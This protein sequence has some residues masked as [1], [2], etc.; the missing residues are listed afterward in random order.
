MEDLC[1]PYEEGRHEVRVHQIRAGP[2]WIDPIVL[3]FKEDILS[4]SK[5]EACKAYGWRVAD[6]SCLPEHGRGLNPSLVEGFVPC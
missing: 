1:K 3:F 2:N 5:F 6:T 4:E